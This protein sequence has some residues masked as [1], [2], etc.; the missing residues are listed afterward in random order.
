MVADLAVVLGSVDVE[1][2]IVALVGGGAAVAGLVAEHA[3]AAAVVVEQP[4]VNF[5]NFDSAYWWCLVARVVVAAESDFGVVT[6][7]DVRWSRCGGIEPVSC[8]W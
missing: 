3:V 2:V 4:T 1:P 5:D 6:N 7:P 8:W